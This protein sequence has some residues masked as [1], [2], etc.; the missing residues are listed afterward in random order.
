M[1]GT[2]SFTTGREVALK[3]LG[4][5]G[6]SKVDLCVVFGSSKYNFS[7][8]VKGVRQVTGNAP[9]IGCSTAGEFTEEKVGTGNIACAVISSD[10]HKFLTGCGTGLR[11]DVLKCLK[12][13]VS[14]FS[15]N[16]KDTE[17]P[18]HTYILLLDGLSGKG[19]EVSLASLSTL[20][21][22]Q[23]IAGGSAADDFQFKETFVFSNDT[24][25]SN[26]LS[27]AQIVSKINMGL[28]V[29]HGHAPVSCPFTVTKAQGNKVYE[30]DGKPAIKV[31]L[32]AAREPAKKFGIDVDTMWQNPEQLAKFTFIFEGGLLTGRHGYKIRWS[33]ITPESKDFLPFVCSVP[34]GSVMRVME[35]SRESEIESSRNAARYA[36]NSMNGRKVAGA[37][38]FDCAVRSALL[39]NEYYKAV[40]AIKGVIGN[41]PFLGVDTY[42][43]VA[44]E[45]GQ[46]SGFHNTTTVVLLIPD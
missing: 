4:K 28:G 32:D 3:A 14:S 36:L 2:D 1:A 21:T 37:L 40:D 39:G 34:E 24:V 13:S 23:K 30:L 44:L 27:V 5:I 45:E 16:S 42:G 11:E 38:V 33:G 19:E 7:E 20:G 9:L 17:Y 43:E 46:L 22:N 29:D 26:A 35:A 25:V 15:L 18:H 41:I 10:T 12:S 31:W 8:V 6:N